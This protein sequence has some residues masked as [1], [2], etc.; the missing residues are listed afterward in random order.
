MPK[1]VVIKNPIS[2][3]SFEEPR[4]HFFFDNERPLLA[5]RTS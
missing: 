3:G 4:R 5:V 1:T 2:N